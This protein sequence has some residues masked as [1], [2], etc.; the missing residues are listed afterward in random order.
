MHAVSFNRGQRDAAGALRPR[1]IA[2]HQPG[3]SKRI[4]YGLVDS[5]R[6]QCAEAV[7]IRLILKLK[8]PGK[9]SRD[10]G[11]LAIAQ[12]QNV[13]HHNRAIG[14]IKRSVPVS[15]LWIHPR[16]T[17]SASFWIA[18]AQ[19]NRQALK[20]RELGNDSKPLMY[21]RRI[22]VDPH[23]HMALNYYRPSF[24]VK[25]DEVEWRAGSA[26]RSILSF[27]AVLQEL[28]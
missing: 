10:F 27:R 3:H 25:R 7:E 6:G 19:H 17:S 18:L 28:S 16:R 20:L 23:S 21:V 22:L 1:S 8:S 14:G 26:C 15:I 11:F 9:H 4:Q 13:V 12:L 5:V 2:V 24:G